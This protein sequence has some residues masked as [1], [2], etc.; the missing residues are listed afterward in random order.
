VPEPLTPSDR[1]MISEDDAGYDSH[2]A[3]SQK[4]PV[5]YDKDDEMIDLTLDD[6][7]EVFS[8]RFS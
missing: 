7:I 6:G 5:H 8:A 1:S 3:T 4:T 2:D